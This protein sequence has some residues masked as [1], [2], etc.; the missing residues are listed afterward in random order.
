MDKIVK[1]VAHAQRSASRRTQR[2][3]RRQKILSYYRAD[4]T[5]KVANREIIDN[6]K[7][8]KKATKEDWELGPLAPQRDLGFNNYGVVTQPIRQDWSNY[9][10]IRYQTKLA[11]QRCAWA[12]G[13]KMLNLAPGDRVVIFEGHDKGKIDTI[14]TIQPETGSLT[15]ETHNRAM[16]KSVTKDTII[17]QLKA[18]PP[19]MESPNMT[20]ERWRYGNKWDRIVPS[21][22]RI[23]PWPETVAPEF[24]MTASDTARDQVEER[25]F[26]YS[27]TASP[28]PEGVIDELRNKYSKFRTR[29]EDWY[30]DAQ[31]AE[32]RAKENRNQKVRDMQ[33]PLEE[34]NE[35][36]RAIRDVAGEPELSE[37]MLAKIGKVMA[38]SKAEVLERSGVS[39]VESK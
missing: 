1:R 19:R 9:G 33:T 16:V 26:Y 36:Q 11:E 15:L 8:A 4:N 14:K 12:G 6:I 27:L 23:I 38:K 22:N 7:D 20:I 37:D 21:L 24:E 18:V 10:Q 2:A 5:I 28:M 30:V 34:F 32:T 35:M 31:E 29:H 3:T 39:E 25:T 13:A 17:R